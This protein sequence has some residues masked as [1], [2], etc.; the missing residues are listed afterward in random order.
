[1]IIV[2][3]TGGIGS[4]KSTVAKI[5]YQLGIPVYD[6]DSRSKNI[7]NTN[8]EIKNF[9]KNEFGNDIYISENQLDTKKLAKYIFNNKELLQKVNS[10][11]HPKVNEDF[12]IWSENQK[13]KYVI[14]EAAI[15]FESG[16]YKQTDKIITVTA[17][18]NVRIERVCKRDNTNEEQVKSRIN[19]QMSDEEKIK[20]SHFVIY[21]DNSK[22]L[23]PQII[24]IHNQILSE[25]F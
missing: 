9:L 24:N 10:I 14:K 20:K 11:I 18:V 21:N 16:S 22:L 2:G 23:I 19:N 12:K 7:V 1:M 6:A 5:F 15:L 3:L 17:P 4:G 13:S 25:E 8:I